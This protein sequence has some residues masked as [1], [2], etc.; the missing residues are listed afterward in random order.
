MAEGDRVEKELKFAGVELDA[1]RGRLL[2]LEAE[3]EW[4]ASLEDNWLFDQGGALEAERCVLR[5]RRDN[6]GAWLTYKGPAHFEGQVK[7]RVEHD[8]AIGD[9]DQAHRILEALGYRVGR[10]YQKMRESWRLGGVTIALDH[11]PMGDFVE[12][13]GEAAEALARRCGFDPETSLRKAYPKLYEEYL[14]DHPDAPRD[15]V[16]TS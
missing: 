10:Q 6:R 8:T 11:T 4:A 2:D 7:V 12:F 16:F 14:K 15:M 9:A 1:L 3:R 13:E 5:L